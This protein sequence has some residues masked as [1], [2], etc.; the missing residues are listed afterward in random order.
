MAF[1]ERHALCLSLFMAI[2]AHRV[3]DRPDRKEPRRLK[4]RHDNYAHMQLPRAQ[5]RAAAMNGR[6]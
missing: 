1:S 2:A 6:E 4:R 3:G 5:A